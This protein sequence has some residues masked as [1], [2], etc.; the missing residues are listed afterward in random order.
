MRVI[1][2]IRT[3]EQGAGKDEVAESKWKEQHKDKEKQQ[4]NSR[5]G[6][7]CRLG[8]TRSGLGGHHRAK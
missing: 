4:D 3:R 6:K 1:I 5:Q 7:G 8:V 2:A